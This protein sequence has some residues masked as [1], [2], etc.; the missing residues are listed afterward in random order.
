MLHVA[1]VLV[2]NVVMVSIAAVAKV[3]IDFARELQE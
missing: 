2:V 3:A 1:A